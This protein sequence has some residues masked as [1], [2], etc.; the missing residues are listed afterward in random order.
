MANENKALTRHGFK[1]DMTSS[2]FKELEASGKQN[3]LDKEL[4]DQLFQS[5]VLPK[6]MIN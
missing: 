6:I 5:F 2:M 4:S 1:E 3:V